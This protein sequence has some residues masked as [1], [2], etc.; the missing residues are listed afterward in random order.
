M[1][2][3]YITY[4]EVIVFLAALLLFGSVLFFNVTSD[5]QTHAKFIQDVANGSSL[6]PAN[7][8]YYAIVYVVALFNTKTIY[9]YAASMLI[10][11]LSVSA[12][13]MLTRIFFSQHCRITLIENR[14][15]ET[16]ISF[17]SVLLLIVFSLP[18]NS[19]FY[20]G[21]IPPNVWHNSTT[22]LVM[23]FALSLFWLS[24]NQLL[25]PTEKRLLIITALCVLN[26]L[27]KPS[28]FFVF[29]LAYPLMLLK[30]F[31]LGRQLWRNLLPI[32][33]S[34]MIVIIMYYL[35]YQLSFGNIKAGK[36][37]I[38]IQ[39]FLVWSRLSP[40][41]ALSL[42]FS[43]V[44]PLA[45]LGFYWRDIIRHTIFQYAAVAFLISIFIAAMFSETGPREF[46]GNFFW[47]G[48]ICNYILF[49]VVAVFFTEKVLATGLRNWKNIT[50][51]VAFMLHAIIGVLYIA[52]LFY[53]K[54]FY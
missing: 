18:T 28:F 30:R 32:I 16:I 17:V 10:L 4:W 15:A 39:P 9:L 14:M 31:G 12:K 27:I 6:P 29:S 26:V 37:E 35:I 38:A 11:S 50:I 25:Q 46:H 52:K 47:Q 41:I 33:I 22:I 19:S 45:Y 2:K 8:I 40:N 24:Y 42:F 5:I 1:Q 54:N 53:T 44:F 51:L 43:L 7:F 36:S 13:F 20:V 49:F 3:K 21:Q 23:P 34:S 48:I